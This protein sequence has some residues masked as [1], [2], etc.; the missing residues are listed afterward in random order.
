MTHSK[1]AFFHNT[2]C[3]FHCHTIKLFT[4][5]WS[6]MAN[7]TFRQFDSWNKR[8]HCLWKAALIFTSPTSARRKWKMYIES[9][10]D[11]AKYNNNKHNIIIWHYNIVVAGTAVKEEARMTNKKGYTR[12]TLDSKRNQK[13]TRTT[14]CPRQLNVSSREWATSGNSRPATW[15]LAEDVD[16]VKREEWMTR[17]KTTW[18]FSSATSL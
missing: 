11:R 4:D 18:W 10:T 17:Q 13:V 9:R 16:L 5:T 15:R 14:K 7:L 2:L 8:Q 6:E 1:F 12:I 3:V